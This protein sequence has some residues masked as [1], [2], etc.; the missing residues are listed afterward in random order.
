ME[1]VMAVMMTFGPAMTHLIPETLDGCQQGHEQ[2]LRH[3]HG[4]PEE[5]A[6]EDGI[7]QGEH[8]L[9]R[10]HRLAGIHT[11]RG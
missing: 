6:A 7:L 8:L 2:H 5:I 9:G 3:Q 10:R 4:G 11:G 1:M